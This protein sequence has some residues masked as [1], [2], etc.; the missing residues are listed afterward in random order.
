M[1]TANIQFYIDQILFFLYLHDIIILTFY[2]KNYIFFLFCDKI[3]IFPRS[4]H[5]FGYKS[6]RLYISVRG[7]KY[8]SNETIKCFNRR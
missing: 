2:I 7:E 8:V 5:F 3:G 4:R 6:V 1:N